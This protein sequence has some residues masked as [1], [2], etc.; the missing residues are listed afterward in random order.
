M[1]D[2]PDEATLDFDFEKGEVIESPQYDAVDFMARIEGYWGT[3]TVTSW[4][5][6]PRSTPKTS[7]PG[8]IPIRKVGQKVFF[9]ATHIPGTRRPWN[10]YGS[11]PPYLHKDVLN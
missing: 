3:A 4:A 6:I 5:K 2:E 10:R 9:N 11:P 1:A 8:V 7:L